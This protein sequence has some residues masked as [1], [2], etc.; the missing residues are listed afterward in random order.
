LLQ[1]RYAVKKA[2]KTFG[3]LVD[4]APRFPFSFLI[5]LIS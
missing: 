1:G 4:Q 5:N 3:A 2:T